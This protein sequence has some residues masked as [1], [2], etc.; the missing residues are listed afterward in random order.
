MKIITYLPLSLALTAAPI[1]AHE[2]D[3]EVVVT[4]EMEL[5]ADATWKHSYDVIKGEKGEENAGLSRA[6]AFYRIM[7]E[8]GVAAERVQVGVVVH[9][10]AIFDVVKDD[11]YAE[12]YGEDDDGEGVRNPNF[13]TVAEL[14]AR[15]A[16]IW[17]CGVAAEFLGVGNEDLLPGVK[18][19]PAAMV[20]NAELQRRG[21]TLNPY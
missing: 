16:E 20:A 1:A 11:R 4:N 14:V 13:N 18:M 3:A 5:P 8:H 12:K 10:P 9:G 2:E 17:V 6:A 19:A 15:G 21:Y 7:E